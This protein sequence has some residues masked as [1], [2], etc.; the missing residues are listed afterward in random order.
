MANHLS[1][2]VDLWERYPTVNKTSQTKIIVG[3]GIQ[4][5]DGMPE[6]PVNSEAW[7]KKLSLQRDNISNIWTRG[8]ITQSSFDRWE[9]QVIRSVAVTFPK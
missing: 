3:L 9:S 8:P 5:D 1:A 6:I 4:S 2:N 7:I